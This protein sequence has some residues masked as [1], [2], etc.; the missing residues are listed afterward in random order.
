MRRLLRKLVSKARR[1]IGTEGLR[2][3]VAALR[4]EVERLLQLSGQR[5]SAPLSDEPAEIRG[6]LNRSLHAP[7]GAASKISQR[8]LANQYRE[9]ARSGGPLLGFEDVE[10][11]AFSQNGEDGILLYIFSLIGMGTRRCV[12]VCAGNGI[13]CNTANLIINHGWNGLMFDGNESLLQRGRAFYA[14]LG[15]TFSFP[16]KIVN[17][18]VNRETINQIIQQNGFEGPIDLLSLDIDG[19]DYWLWEALEVVR[20]RVVVAEIQCIW[21]ADRAVTVP[22]SPHFKTE[23][24]DGFGVYSGASL[25]AFVKLARR[26]GYRLV[27]VQRLGFNAFFVENGVGEDLLPEVSIE[28][29]IDFPFVKWARRDLLNKVKHLPWVEV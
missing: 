29:C 13:E 2:G 3:D 8:V 7:G 14:S 5:C 11:R 19:V 4:I 25:P 10:F 18:W 12:E 9:L 24:I 17:A 16:P 27:G 6:L 15:D 20:P 21:G 22:Y 26:K 28:S 1:A 23:S